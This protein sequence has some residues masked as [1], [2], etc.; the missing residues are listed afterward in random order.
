MKTKRHPYVIMEQQC[1]PVAGGGI[2]QGA[3]F[4]EI[5][6]LEAIPK[7]WLSLAWPSRI[8]FPIGKIKPSYNGGVSAD[9][10]PTDLK[11][12]K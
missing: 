11:I 6:G 1:R 10:Q 3:K 9:D 4:H 2:I 7:N 8:G 5:F 12:K